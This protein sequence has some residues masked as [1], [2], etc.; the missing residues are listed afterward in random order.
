MGSFFRV[1]RQRRG[2]TKLASFCKNAAAAMP[3]RRNR[4]RATP[5]R[6]TLSEREPQHQVHQWLALNIGGGRFT[7]DRTE[8]PR[9]LEI[10]RRVRRGECKVVER[11]LE[12]E[13]K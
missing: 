2:R 5:P 4:G 12:I 11:V 8:D 13:P 1:A 10:Q 6:K 9:V 3:I 7:R